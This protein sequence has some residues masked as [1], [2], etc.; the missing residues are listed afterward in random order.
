MLTNFVGVIFNSLLEYVRLGTVSY[1]VLP[2]VFIL[3]RVVKWSNFVFVLKFPRSVC[4]FSPLVVT[5]FLVQLWSW[6]AERTLTENCLNGKLHGWR[7][8]NKWSLKHS[9]GLPDHSN[10]WINYLNIQTDV[11]I[12]RTDG[13]LFQTL[14]AN[15]SNGLSNTL[16]GFF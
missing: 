15:R 10:G 14:Y 1:S 9:N 11:T 2:F 13:N 6:K 12:L 8:V 4:L 7:T 5:N 16:N 3:N